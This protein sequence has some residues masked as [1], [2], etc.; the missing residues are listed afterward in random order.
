MPLKEGRTV[1]VRFLKKALL[2]QITHG[3]VRRRS[4]V[5]ATGNELRSQPTGQHLGD[6]IEAIEIDGQIHRPHWL[7]RLSS[8]AT[9]PNP[10]WCLGNPSCSASRSRGVDQSAVTALP[11]K[12]TI[13][14]GQRFFRP[15]SSGH[16]QNCPP[17][18]TQ[19]HDAGA[20]AQGFTGVTLHE[21]FC[22]RLRLP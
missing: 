9:D 15:R 22:G 19:H 14:S 1:P 4:L 12:S 8:L 3:K 18:G 2:W 21:E 6:R 20:I 11:M 10:R 17:A 5:G 16:T 13:A 7:W